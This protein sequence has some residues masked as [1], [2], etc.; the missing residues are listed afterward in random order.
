MNQS[1]QAL[2]IEPATPGSC[3]EAFELLLSGTPPDRRKESLSALIASAKL[4]PSSLDFLYEARRGGLLVG[5]AW[6]QV[7]PG[8]CASFWPP[9]LRPGEN[10][11]VAEL[12]AH[13]V[14][15]R[16]AGR[17]VRV[18]QTL[19]T[20]DVGTTAGRLERAN[21]EHLADLLYLVSTEAD[22]PATRIS[23]DLSFE[24]ADDIGRVR[25]LQSMIEA[26]YEKTLD[27]PDLNGVR[28]SEDVLAGYRAVGEFDARRWL[29]LRHGLQDV[30]CLLLADYPEV[31]QWE[32]VYMGLKAAS[33]GQGWGIE[34]VRHAQWLARQAGRSRLVLAVDDRNEPAKRI[35]GETGFSSWDRRSVYI[36]VIESA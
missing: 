17:G 5:A 11:T 12:L 19:L 36:A 31:Q 30:G 29:I 15:D 18:A 7:M 26:T 20:T 4:D 2:Q 16:L 24:P 28:S 32:L 23:T 34:V 6:A 1:H 14:M 35:Y 21:F 8:R 9:E 13:A 33:R 25:R 27:C 10:E 22:F 3:R